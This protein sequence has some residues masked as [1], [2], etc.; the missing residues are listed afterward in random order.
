M[1][2]VVACG[3]VSREREVSL[4]SGQMVYDSLKRQGYDVVLLDV[5]TKDISHDLK[6]ISAD[7]CFNLLHGSFGEDGCF[8]AICESIGL[9]YTGSSVCSSALTMN[10]V[11]TKQILLSSKKRNTKWC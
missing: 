11:L 7:V 4:V 10:K 8:Q 1:K 3:G 2:I 6:N 5:K 9:L